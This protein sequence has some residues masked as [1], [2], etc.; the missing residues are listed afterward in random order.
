MELKCNR[1]RT[2]IL[3]IRIWYCCRGYIKG[4]NI[5]HSVYM[6]LQGQLCWGCHRSSGLKQGFHRIEL[7]TTDSSPHKVYVV[8][9]EKPFR[10]S[11]ERF[12]V[13]RQNVHCHLCYLTTEPFVF[14]CITQPMYQL[15]YMTVRSQLAIVKPTQYLCLSVQFSLWLNS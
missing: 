11:C 4:F 2:T 13:F 3:S 1:H 9:H 7:E 14:L 15:I 8:S 10:C 12:Y 6:K 5:N